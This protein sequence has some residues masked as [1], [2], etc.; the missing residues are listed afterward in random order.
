[1]GLD[2]FH[3]F[4]R[5]LGHFSCILWW[6]RRQLSEIC[7]CRKNVLHTQLF[8]GPLSRTTRVDRYQK[9][10]LPTHTWNVLWESVIILDFMRRGEDNR[11]KCID[12]PTG[13]HPVQ[14]IDAPTSIIPPPQF[15]AGCFTSA[16][17]SIYPG[18]E[19]SPNMLDCLVLQVL[20]V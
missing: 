6:G 10:H 1:M 4:S 17:L 8:Y 19:L 7:Q 11:G 13:C 3:Y 20:K 5:S 16:T 18:L 14:T 2:S 9:R 12:S 15:Y